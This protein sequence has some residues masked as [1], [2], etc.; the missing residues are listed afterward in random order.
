MTL[1]TVLRVIRSYLAAALARL[2]IEIDQPTS[3]PVTEHKDFTFVTDQAIRSILERDYQEIQRAF[4]AKC[5]KSVIILTGGAVEAIL[6]DLLLTHNSQAKSSSKAPKSVDIRKWS[7]N[8]LIEVAV[9]LKLVSAGIEKLSHSLRE[10]RNLI[11]P[12]NEVRSNLVFDAEEAKI[13]LEVLNILHRD[14]S[15]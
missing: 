11:H 5:W 6:T 3:T 2:K 4:I 8:D 12:G 10:Y 7:L 13:A 1:V 15:P 9:D 14:L